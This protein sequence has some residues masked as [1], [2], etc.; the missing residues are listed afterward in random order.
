VVQTLALERVSV[1]TARAE[2]LGRSADFRESADI[3]TAR[4][5]AALP[6]LL[7]LCSPFVIPGG[8]LAFPKSGDIPAEVARGREAA[9]AVRVS[10]R[11]LV[12]VPE[13]LG[14]GS[15][16]AIAVYEKT[17]NTPARFPRRVGLATSQPIELAK[18]TAGGTVRPSQEE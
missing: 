4:A 5:V 12:P 6:A 9:R 18:S 17:G 1:Q 7:E 2:E 15:G 10:F 8:L 16:R 11:S 14:L 3:C 13:K